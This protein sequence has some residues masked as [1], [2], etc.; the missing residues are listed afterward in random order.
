M[1]SKGTIAARVIVYLLGNMALACA[2][3]FIEQFFYTRKRLQV[4]RSGTFDVFT[5]CLWI[6][7]F[8]FGFVI[9][10]FWLDVIPGIGSAKPGDLAFFMQTVKYE[11]TCLFEL[12]TPCP[13]SVWMGFMFVL[14][15]LVEM[16]LLIKLAQDSANFVQVLSTVSSPLV[17][18]FWIAFPWWE[19]QHQSWMPYSSLWQSMPLWSVL[20][21]FFIFLI[22]TIVFKLWEMRQNSLIRPTLAYA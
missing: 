9:L 15:W 7:I 8:Q 4:R 5:L 10:L 6:S 17:I 1:D 13:D 2:P 19:V 14:S 16:L 21:A 18:C 20:P 12:G 3:I 11:S 22:G